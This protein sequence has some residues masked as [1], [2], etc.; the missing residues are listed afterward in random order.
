MTV[1]HYGIPVLCPTCK[2][3]VWDGGH[4]MNER[5]CDEENGSVCRLTDELARSRA[6]RDAA[7]GLLAHIHED[8]DE[9]DTIA[10]NKLDD[11]IRK[12]IKAE[13]LVREACAAGRRCLEFDDRRNLKF[14]AII[15][16][17]ETP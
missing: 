5:E 11:T 14:D 4:A 10:Q 17:L 8:D 9:A 2:R 1:T 6:E 7:Q 15:S 16:E 13:R 3:P 12:L